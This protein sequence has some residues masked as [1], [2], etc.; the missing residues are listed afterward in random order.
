MKKH[1]LIAAALVVSASGFAQGNRK[2]VL[3]KPVK[4]TSENQIDKDAF[5]VAGTKAVSGPSSQPTSS[6]CN[7]PRF[8]SCV[9]V[10]AVGGGVT[11]YQQNCLSYNKDLNTVTW[12]SR[13][14]A[15]W[16]FTGA[17]S[18]AI[19][20]TWVD[21]NTGIWDSTILYRNAPNGHGARYP[22]GVM[23]NPPGNTSVANA[24]LVGSGSVTG[25]TGWLGAWYSSRKADANHLNT[26][27]TDTKYFQA[28]GTAPFG[29]A[30]NSLTN[31]GFINLDMQQVGNSVMV[32]SALFDYTANTETKG[33]VIGKATY[34]AS[35]DSL[36]W[37][38]D[39]IVP[40]FLNT[41]LGLITDG[42]GGRLA[43]SP[44]G[45]TGYCVFNGRL[46]NTYGNNA[47]SSMM[48][49]VYKSIDGGATWNMVLGGY[50]WTMEHPEIRK[51]VGALLGVQGM[52]PTPNYQHGTDLTVDA[53]GVLHYVTTITMPFKDGTV[54][55]GHGNHC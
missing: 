23:F 41:P 44:D 15:D 13:R 51:N 31:C 38:A 28:V 32:G 4:A 24:F 27:I 49:I 19:Q 40:G 50:D 35:G 6:I 10:F 21:V 18:G 16:A 5:P 22:G 3:N 11:T 39:S 53:N 45:M 20:S 2:A 26:A 55:K 36:V 14:S 46:A 52:H 7:P 25:G 8:T 9:N 1:L 17:T 54:I 43:F 30:G 33:A 48:P 12:T 37:S 29:N 42:L 47:D 34:S